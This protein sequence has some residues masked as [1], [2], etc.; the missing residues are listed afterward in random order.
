VIPTFLRMKQLKDRQ[1]VKSWPQLRGLQE[2]EGFPL[3]RLIGS[4]RSWTE[5]EIAAWLESRPVAPAPLRGACKRRSEA[6]K[7]RA[8]TEAAV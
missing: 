4:V 3:G 7:A 8:E 6:K 5:D 1:I 2:R